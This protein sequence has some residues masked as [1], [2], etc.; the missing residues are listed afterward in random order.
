MD[1]NVEAFAFRMS[2]GAMFF[3]QSVLFCADRVIE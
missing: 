1:E 2:Q 3:P